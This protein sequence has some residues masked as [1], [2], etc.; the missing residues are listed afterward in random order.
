MSEVSRV[1]V[2]LLLGAVDPVSAERGVEFHL[3]LLLLL[4]VSN[5]KLLQERL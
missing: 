4:H 1:L 3:F 2:I 5:H